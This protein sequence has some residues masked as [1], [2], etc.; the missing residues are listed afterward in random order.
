MTQIHRHVPGRVALCV[1]A[2]IISGLAP[3]LAQS[4]PDWVARSN[5]HTRVV[6]E[7]QAKL[8]PESAA[9]IGVSGVDEQIT[10]LSP[11]FNQRVRES[12][13]RVQQE[14]QRRLTA[15]KD[16]LVRQDLEI[17]I[18]AT[19]QQLRALDINERLLLPYTNVP[20]AV[21]NSLRSLLDDQVPQERRR[22]ALVRLRK[23]T[24][25]ETGFKP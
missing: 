23:Y 15:D 18:E 21:F 17:L 2:T 1:A 16:P 14:L 3:G 20:A 9:Q 12:L 25:A 4:P 24:G 11:G 6:L 5:E 22:A 13:T 8:A 19:R 7:A 10:D